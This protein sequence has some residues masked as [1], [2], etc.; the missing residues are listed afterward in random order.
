MVHVIRKIAYACMLSVIGLSITNCSPALKNSETQNSIDIADLLQQLPAQDAV[1]GQLVTAEIIRQAPSSFRQIIPLLNSEDIDQKIR[2][3]YAISLLT[4]HFGRSQESEFTLEY[5]NVIHQSIMTSQ[6]ISTTNLLIRQ[7]ELCGTD[8]S[9]EFLTDYLDADQVSDAAIRAMV[10]INAQKTAQILTRDLHKIPARFQPAFIKTLGELKYRDSADIILPHTESKNLELRQIA[11][12]SLANMGYI[13]AESVIR[14]QM[15]SDIRQQQAN[16]VAN[17]ILWVENLNDDSK[18]KSLVTE[19]I[20]NKEGLFS[21]HHRLTFMNDCVNKHCSDLHTYLDLLLKENNQKLTKES[22]RMTQSVNGSE[23]TEWLI[24]QAKKLPIKREIVQT[25]GERGDSNALSF[26]SA[27]IMD[28]SYEV[29]KATIHAIRKLNDHEQLIRYLGSC[30]EKITCEQLAD[31]LKYINKNDLI[32][33]I[34]S[35]PRESLSPEFKIAI[36][37]IISERKLNVLIAFVRAL[38]SDE[39]TDVRIAAMTT[40]TTLDDGLSLGR[41]IDTVFKI[42]DKKE[43]D[44]AV[45]SIIRLL[46]V[47]PERDWYL[48]NLQPN[49]V[50]LNP[51]SLDDYFAILK[52]VGGFKAF[53]ILQHEIQNPE[54]GKNEQA[55]EMLYIWPDGYALDTLMIIASESTELREKVKS[56]RGCLHILRENEFPEYT[57]LR[58]YRSLMPVASRPEEKQMI[59]AEVMKIHSPE[60]LDFIMV[61]LYDPDLRETAIHAVVRMLGDRNSEHSAVSI[62][63]NLMLAYFPKDSLQKFFRENIDPDMNQP[64]EGFVALFNGTDLSGWKG[65]V[66]DP[67][68]RKK[69]SNNQPDSL[70]KIADE[71]MR[72]HWYVENG[73]LRFDG[74]GANLCTIKDFNDF[75]LWVDWKIE[76]NGDSGIYLRGMPQVQIKDQYMPQGGSGGLYNNKI[77]E[78]WPLE[79]ADREPGKWNR[80]HIIMVGSKVTVSLNG[81]LVVDN[82]RLENYW[83]RDR[84]AYET[85]PIELQAHNSPLYFKNIFIKELPAEDKQEEIIF[86][87]RDLSGW[88]AIHS[89]INSWHVSD[90]ILF[91]DGFS[92]GWLSSERQYEDF[93]LTFEFRVSPGGNSGIFIRAPHQGDPAYSGIEIQVLDDY[94]EKYANLKSWQYTGSL[95]GVVSAKSGSSYKANQWQKMKIICDGPDIKVSLNGTGIIDAN[96]IDHMW[97]EDSHPG[98]KR[99]MG[100]IGLQAHGSKVEY[101]NI[102]IKVL[103]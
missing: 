90:S 55:L 88:Q 44:I 31:E 6:D 3:Q 75:E 15:K 80:F 53:K 13:P 61:Q 63:K 12:F 30:E 77:G 28:T 76:K 95:Y 94:A 1:T 11:C 35:V 98:L 2:A 5:C 96:L 58:Y 10:Q 47:S 81:R 9:L 49:R 36:L 70:Q 54:K 40:V 33:G 84:D 22:L 45:K 25:L 32:N 39:N 65:L 21:Q 72:S 59:L 74:R 64:P 23:M 99:R 91:T 71:Q 73:I 48:A 51:N 20:E 19:V 83:E 66:A 102:I 62:S 41:L 100:F 78:R 24:A 50:N 87:G 42:E 79:I 67:V 29:Q 60:A 85:G 101:K 34:I 57:K 103:Q 86:N 37:K 43:S 93:E 17:F 26:L 56:I 97:Q 52:G 18:R 16:G 8:E 68:R 4:D 92:G 7:L 89:D 14:S 82:I 27:M 69:M 46:R 38:I